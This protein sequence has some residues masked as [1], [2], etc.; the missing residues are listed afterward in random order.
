MASIAMYLPVF[1]VCQMALLL[2][3]PRAGVGFLDTVW[4]TALNNIDM[5]IVTRCRIGKCVE[6]QRHYSHEMRIRRKKK[7]TWQSLPIKTVPFTCGD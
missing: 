7:A 4:S 3:G 5:H 1:I 6:K 2:V